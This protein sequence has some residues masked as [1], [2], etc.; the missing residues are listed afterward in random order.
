M[1]EGEKMARKRSTLTELEVDVLKVLWDSQT[2]LTVN[3]ITEK[4]NAAGMMLS[5]ASVAQVMKKLLEKKAVEVAEHKLTANIYSRAF[6]SVMSREDY[7]N[8]EIRRLQ[9]VLS[10]NRQ[11]STLGLFQT[12][13]QNSGN[14]LM[15]EKD[16]DEM[17]S[18][19]KRYLQ[20][21]GKEEK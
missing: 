21:D 19:L 6:V 5:S 18:I 4:M 9:N 14:G 16:I 15:D 20:D 17:E 8:A 3:E 12:L 11:V 13:L 10:I 1:H 2:S 7:M